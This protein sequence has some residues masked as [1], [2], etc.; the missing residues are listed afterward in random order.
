MTDYVLKLLTRKLKEAVY[1]NRIDESYEILTAHFLTPFRLLSKDYSDSE[2]RE[3]A[4]II[5]EV[6]EVVRDARINKHGGD[7]TDW[8]LAQLNTSATSYYNHPLRRLAAIYGLSLQYTAI[9]D[10]RTTHICSRLHGL[11]L[12]PMD[13]RLKYLTPPNHY[14]CRSRLIPIKTR[15][16]PANN[17]SRRWIKKW[18]TEHQL[19]VDED[20]LYV[21]KNPK[22]ILLP[23]AVRK[24]YPELK[25]YYKDMKTPSI[26]KRLEEE[27][28]GLQ[29]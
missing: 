22:E 11:A 25:D 8:F 26:L 19:E 21:V 20:F 28:R 29:K 6:N 16:A 7:R 18:T 2:R 5:R 12:H 3:A 4:E 17:L 24:K 14:N 1:T 9:L 10:S 23:Y 27:F 13:D 15:T